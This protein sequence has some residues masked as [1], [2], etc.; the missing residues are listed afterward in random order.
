[1]KK[2][3][4]EWLETTNVPGV[5]VRD[6]HTNCQPY[7]SDQLLTFDVTVDGVEITGTGRFSQTFVD[8]ETEMTQSVFYENV[9]PVLLNLQP[10]E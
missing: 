9:R 5:V 3:F 7:E 2:L 1:M 6:F 4:I 8:G 10:S